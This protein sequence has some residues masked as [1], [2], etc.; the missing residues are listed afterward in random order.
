MFAYRRLSF[1]GG[2][3][4]SSTDGCVSR[5]DVLVHCQAWIRRAKDNWYPYHHQEKRDGYCHRGT[6]VSPLIGA[7]P[8]TNVD[9]TSSDP[10]HAPSHTH[11]LACMSRIETGG[12]S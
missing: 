1:G 12:T 3:R 2:S 5:A 7:T 6:T 8:S 4:S 10:Q 9:Y 11:V